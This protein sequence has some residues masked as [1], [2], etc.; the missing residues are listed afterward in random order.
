MQSSKVLAKES[1]VGAV[2]S[3]LV[4][5][6][7]GSGSI[8]CPAVIWGLSLLVLYSVLSGFSLGTPVFPC[9]QKPTFDLICCDSA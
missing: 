8:S 4:F 3:A 1:R 7:Y 9:H 6:L 5:H 2:A